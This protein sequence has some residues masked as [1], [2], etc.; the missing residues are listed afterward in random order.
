[1]N[2]E[3]I[4]DDKL[5]W[6]PKDPPYTLF[7]KRNPDYTGAVSVVGHGLGSLILFDLLS[8]Q[9]NISPAQVMPTMPTTN[10]VP[11]VDTKQDAQAHNTLA[12]LVEEPK[13][14]GDE[15]EDLPAVLQH[16]GLSEY[17]STFDEE[18]IDVESLLMCTIEDLKEMGIPLGPRKKIA[19]FVKDR[20]NKQVSRHLL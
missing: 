8:N 13:E 9:K 20:L 7:M 19:K 4:P 2:N 3:Q 1:M 16:L 6:L 14:K 15:F 17:K 11:T 5:I 12:S 18:K 10:E